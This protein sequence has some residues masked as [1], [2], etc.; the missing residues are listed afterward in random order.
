MEFELT[1]HDV[2]S[3][4][5]SHYAPGTPILACEMTYRSKLELF[6]IIGYVISRFGPVV[7]VLWPIKFCRLSN[8]KSIFM[9]IVLFQTI[10]F[11]MSTQFNCQKHSYFKLINLFKQF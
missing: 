6:N 3:E 7:Q 11:R 2:T 10:Q 9:Q 5:I 8:A 4:H 1:Y